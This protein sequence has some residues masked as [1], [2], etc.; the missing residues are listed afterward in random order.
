M[1]NKK[2]H[3][4]IV[5][6]ASRSGKKLFGLELAI[7]LL[8]NDQKTALLLPTDSPLCSIIEN[9]KKSHPELPSPQVIHRHN[10]DEQYHN[11]DAIIIPGISSS[12]E[13]AGYVDTYITLLSSPIRQFQKN[14]AYINDMWEL[15]KK[16][17]SSHNKSLN[18]VIC[19]NNLKN[20]STDSPSK[21]LTNMAKMYGFRVAPPINKRVP[22]LNTLEGISSQDKITTSLKNALTYEDICAKREI[23]KLAEF[24]FQ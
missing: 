19:E 2:A 17:A 8:Y 12:D 21:E 9:R 6:G 11:Y 22:Y 4:V 3:I 24:I 23:I 1:E 16:I 5:D 14:N 13:L 10:F 15:K 20:K 7:T 18:W